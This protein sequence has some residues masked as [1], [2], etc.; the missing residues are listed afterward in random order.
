MQRF[1][2]PAVLLIAH[3]VGTLPADDVIV[4]ETKDA[5]SEKATQSSTKES[6]PEG[7]NENS[8]LAAAY[9]AWAR[10]PGKV[11]LAK[12]QRLR[13]DFEGKFALPW[14]VKRIDPDH[15]SLLAHKGHLT[16]T[17]QLGHIHRSQDDHP[18]KN[19]FL[20]ENPLQEG[21]FRITMKVS[22]F[23]PTVHFQQLALLCYDDDD[24]YLKW[25]YE[26]SW[27]SKKDIGFVLIRETNRVSTHA[28]SHKAKLKAFWLRIT[29][30]GNSYECGFS[31]DGKDFEIVGE[32]PWGN[33]SPKY[34]GFLAK[35]GGNEEAEEIEAQIDWFEVCALEPPSKLAGRS[36]AS[37]PAT[38]ERLGAEYHA[39]F[40]KKA[41]DHN[42]LLPVGHRSVFG[43]SMYRR[44]TNGLRITIPVDQGRFKPYVGV[45]PALKVCGDFEITAS[46][47][48]FMAD[49]PREGEGAGA[50]L[51]IMTQ[52]SSNAAMLRR[53]TA[54]DGTDAYMVY[55]LIR[56]SNRPKQ[57]TFFSARGAKGQ[58]QL[59]RTGSTLEY[60]VS[61]G[62]SDDFHTLHS[63]EFGNDEIGMLRME[64]TTG[65]AEVGVQVRWQD[66]VIRADKLEQIEIPLFQDR[67]I[68]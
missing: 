48:F 45:T 38:P 67:A 30:R 59:A 61:D 33:G 4:P 20:L 43:L 10:G 36:G 22:H 24:N 13:D 6:S 62:S 3:L 17:T 11:V 42:I 54:P 64:N 31:R 44:E 49:R 29:K 47:D 37:S 58:L 18:A 40:R 39:D 51:Y 53:C 32:C 46:Y 65:G 60:R 63:V 14:I 27:V 7:Q 55:Q 21:D 52:G 26:K 12:G 25:S 19:L 66:L 16:I 9:E 23:A 35:N 15:F 57:I 34:L 50:N 28:L 68:H 1:T 56:R 2:V 41:F 8:P 5:S